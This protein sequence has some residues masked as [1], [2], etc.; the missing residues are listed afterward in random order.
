MAL[1]FGFCPCPLPCTLTLG[2]TL[3]FA[4]WP[5]PYHYLCPCPCPCTVTLAM[6]LTFDF[7]I[8]R[9]PLS[10]PLTL[11]LHPVPEYGPDL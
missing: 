4:S 2:M 9:L 8:L 10:W 5:S 3:T 11:T 1:T 6:I 7:W